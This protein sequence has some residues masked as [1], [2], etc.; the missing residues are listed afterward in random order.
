MGS[1]TDKTKYKGLYLTVAKYNAVQLVLNCGMSSISSCD[2][3]TYM[4]GER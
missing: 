1:F 3:R 2:Q 4:L